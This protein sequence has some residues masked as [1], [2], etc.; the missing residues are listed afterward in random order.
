MTV[1]LGLKSGG[2]VP[3][4]P[5]VHATDVERPAVVLISLCLSAALL[6]H[7]PSLNIVACDS[8]R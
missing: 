1:P 6:T 8:I 5:G 7:P 4:P 2:H 3:L